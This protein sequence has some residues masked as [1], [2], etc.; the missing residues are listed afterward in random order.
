MRMLEEQFPVFPLAGIESAYRAR[1]VAQDQFLFPRRNR[2]L[3]RQDVEAYTVLFI[4]I[5]YKQSSSRRTA[6]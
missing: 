4:L 2:L 6:L 3:F 5:R 1:A